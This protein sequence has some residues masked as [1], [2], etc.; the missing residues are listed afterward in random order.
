[1]A[2]AAPRVPGGLREVLAARDVLRR[3]SSEHARQGIEGMRTAYR[4]PAAAVRAAVALARSEGWPAVGRV[5][6]EEPERLG[7]L[8]GERRGPLREAPV[9]VQAVEAARRA[10][11]AAGR[12]AAVRGPRVAD[13]VRVPAFG[14]ALP[15]VE[16]LR[17]ARGAAQGA[18][19]RA[20]WAAMRL[21]LQSVSFV[22]R[23]GA[24]KAVRLAVDVARFLP[25]EHER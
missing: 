10:G 7:A 3:G 16:G 21:G 5:L 18:Q 2:P 25:R 20:A 8:R 22:L 19:A 13:V 6:R 23:P 24:L 14:S 17:P 12:L 11:W 15:P 9:R 4:D 1:V